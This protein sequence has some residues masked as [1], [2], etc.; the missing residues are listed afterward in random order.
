MPC[1]SWLVKLLCILCTNKS[2]DWSPHTLQIIHLT[3]LRTSYVLA[4]M[5]YY[6]TTVSVFPR[7]LQYYNPR[8]SKQ[9]FISDIIHSCKLNDASLNEKS[10]T[11]MLLTLHLLEHHK[12]SY[13]FFNVM[14]RLPICTVLVL[15]CLYVLSYSPLLV[16]ICV[17]LLMTLKSEPTLFE[18]S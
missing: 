5:W 1:K 7:F 11:R 14:S 18:S 10:P 16:S 13:Q 2:R 4:L 15:P 8:C 17:R 12:I 3:L 6:A 9:P